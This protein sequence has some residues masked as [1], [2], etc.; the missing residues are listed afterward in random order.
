MD[1]I[2]LPWDI[3]IH[4]YVYIFIYIYIIVL[5]GIAKHRHMY[6][7]SLAH[8][9]WGWACFANRS[10]WVEVHRLIIQGSTSAFVAR[11][12]MLTVPFASGSNSKGN[13]PV[14]SWKPHASTS[15]KYILYMYIIYRE[16]CQIIRTESP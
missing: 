8:R 1:G 2:P 14:Q 16:A 9:V 15:G 13:E 11:P 4:I 3:Y 6:I 5:L 7:I 12:N 10:K